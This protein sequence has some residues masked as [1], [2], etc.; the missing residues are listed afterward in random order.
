M[1]SPWSVFILYSQIIVNMLTFDRHLYSGLLYAAD[2]NAFTAFV[3]KLVLAFY[4]IWNLDFIPNIIPPFCLNIS[5]WGKRELVIEYVVA[6]YP[7]M[8]IASM[9]LCVHLH[10]RD[11]KLIVCKVLP[12][13]QALLWNETNCTESDITNYC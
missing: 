1:E 3:V 9:Y 4:G 10:S 5:K 8:I 12:Q 13:F 11:V 7:L 2:D 6:S